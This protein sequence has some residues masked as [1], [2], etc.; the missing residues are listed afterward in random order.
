MCCN[1]RDIP[2]R[3]PC[4][5]RSE[6]F[7]TITKFPFS[8]VWCSVEFWL[9]CRQ[10]MKLEPKKTKNLYQLFDDCFLWLGRLDQDQGPPKFSIPR[11]LIG[12]IIITLFFEMFSHWDFMF[13]PS[14]PF[15]ISTAIWRMFLLG[16]LSESFKYL[17]AG[18]TWRKK[19]PSA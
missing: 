10:V 4:Q 16:F 11:M 5:W 13:A 6:G 19:K 8:W 15:H 12:G 2:A 3:K 18:R 1:L 9:Y 7:A 14:Q 17:R